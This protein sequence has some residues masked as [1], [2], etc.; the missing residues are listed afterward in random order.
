[1]FCDLVGSTPLAASFPR[2]PGRR[3]KA[4]RGDTSNLKQAKRL[5]DELT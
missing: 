2:R 5:L 1:M 3:P 4:H